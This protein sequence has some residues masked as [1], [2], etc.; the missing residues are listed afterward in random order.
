MASLYL[1]HKIRQ[2][3]FYN[4]DSCLLTS[5]ELSCFLF[6]FSYDH[7]LLTVCCECFYC[8]LYLP[9]VLSYILISWLIKHWSTDCFHQPGGPCCHPPT[10]V[11]ALR[12]LRALKDHSCLSFVRQIQERR[13]GFFWV[14]RP[15]QF[16]VWQLHISRLSFS[17]QY[18]CVVGALSR[19]RCWWLSTTPAVFACLS[20]CSLRLLLN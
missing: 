11:K 8:F 13:T 17:D 10:G 12:K 18:G 5:V 15:S 1:S 19:C 6:H 20:T 4:K 2:L 14:D 3:Q 7:I 9:S 16:G